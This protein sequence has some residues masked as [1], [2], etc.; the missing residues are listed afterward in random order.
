MVLMR[1]NYTMKMLF[2][3]RFDMKTLSDK[4]ADINAVGSFCDCLS[5]EEPR[6]PAA[7]AFCNRAKTGKNATADELAELKKALLDLY[8]PVLDDDDACCDCG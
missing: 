1:Y 8:D 5:G 2:R 4:C 7:E 6:D 3:W